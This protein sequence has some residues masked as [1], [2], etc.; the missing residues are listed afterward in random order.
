MNVVAGNVREGAAQVGVDPVV[1]LVDN[2]RRDLNCAALIAHH[3]EARGI[4]CY[5]EPLEAFRAVVGA[6]RP[7]MVIFNHLNASHLAAWSRRLAEI[8]VL[9]GVL[10]NEGIIYQEESRP[11]M[12]GRYH[13]DAHVDYFFVWN[14]V[15]GDA[16]RAEGFDRT[17]RIET[18]GVPRFDFYFE[19]WS[20]T[21]PSVADRRSDR[22]RVLL[23]TNFIFAK[24]YDRMEDAD[25]LFAGKQQTNSLV[26][27]YPKAVQSHWRSRQRV[28]LYMQT[29]LQDG[30]F[31]VLL[32]PHPMEESAYYY[33]WLETLP[34]A[35]RSRVDIDVSSDIASLILDCDLQI[36]CETCT[37]AVESWIAKKPTIELIFD[38]HP[39]L[40]KDTQAVA[41]FPCDSAVQLPAMVAQHLASPDQP[42][43]QEVRARHLATWCATPDG[44]SSE[45]LADLIVEAVQTKKPSDWT[46]LKFDD[47]RRAVKLKGTRF[48]GEAYHFDPVL[49]LRQL[50]FHAQAERRQAVYQKSIKPA[51]VVKARGKL[52]EA[53][54]QG[55]NI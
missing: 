8:G 19:P 43:R 33:Q 29:L 22:P 20:R 36:S 30:R 42:E 23:C 21:L 2:K 32:R 17:A 7:G 38:K 4:R 25:R 6:Y 26:R 9:V 15:H 47:Y 16:I 12:S 1:I 28:S 11:F 54:N 3:V 13:R 51:D 27:D 41:N 44:R 34:E 14:D 53:L 55:R 46:S 49:P 31:D 5:L 40:Y 35:L 39:M 37:T 48:I 18:V 52:R 10:P 45:R 50:L 24:M